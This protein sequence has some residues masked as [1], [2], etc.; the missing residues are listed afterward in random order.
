MDSI[1]V[2]LFAMPQVEYEE[3][4]YDYMLVSVCRAS[5]YI[6]AQPCKGEGLTA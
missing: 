1:A 4:T 5:G 2:D 3:K 6:L